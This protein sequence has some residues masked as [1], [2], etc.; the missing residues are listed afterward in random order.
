MRLARRFIQK[1]IYIHL[2]YRH[3]FS[4]LLYWIWI[5]FVFL[6][7]YLSIC[8]QNKISYGY[9]LMKIGMLGDSR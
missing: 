7:V 4:T 6:F 2:C 1:N 3:I 9:I 8:V 5:F